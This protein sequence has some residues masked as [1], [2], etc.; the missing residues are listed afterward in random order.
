[1]LKTLATIQFVKRSRDCGTSK[2]PQ[3][4][5]TPTRLTGDHRD[6]DGKGIHFSPKGLKT[7]GQMWAEKLLPF[8]DARMATH[9]ESAMAD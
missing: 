9:P 2:S 8:V 6:F 4:G 1:M 7:H 5:Q 3:Q